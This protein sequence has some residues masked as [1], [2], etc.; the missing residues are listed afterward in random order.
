[1]NIETRAKHLT[2][3]D[4]LREHIRQKLELVAR[5]FGTRVDGVVVRLTDVNGPRGGSDKRCRILVRK[6]SQ[7]SFVVQALCADA[8]DAVTQAVSVLDERL[9]RAGRRRQAGGAA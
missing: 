1:M 5:R 3:S 8:Y 6:A 2:L 7:P 9:E 4:A